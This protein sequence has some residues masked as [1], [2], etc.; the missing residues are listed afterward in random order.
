MAVYL[1]DEARSE[2]R[3]AQ[4]QLDRHTD[5]ANDGRCPVCDLDGPCPLKRAAL[6]VFVRYGRLPG[7]RP[8]ATHPQL[9]GLR[10]DGG[11]EFWFGRRSSDGGPDA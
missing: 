3:A 6:R 9:V 10:R 5:L 1:T 4:R 11:A 8:G 2:L 7:R